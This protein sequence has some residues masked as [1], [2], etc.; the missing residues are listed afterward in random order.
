VLNVLRGG[1]SSTVPE[2]E[3]GD[4][5]LYP[6]PARDWVV[7]EYKDE[8][9]KQFVVHSLQVSD[10]MGRK[11]P[12]DLCVEDDRLEWSVATWPKGTYI[13]Q[14]LENGIPTP[15]LLRLLVD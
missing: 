3:Y 1:L 2:T 10:V 13:V 6:N 14:L 11:M 8:A 12:V 5:V 4:W 9:N 15:Q 7:L